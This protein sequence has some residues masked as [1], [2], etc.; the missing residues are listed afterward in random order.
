[1]IAKKHRISSVEEGSIAQEAG[2]SAGDR[3]ISING[4]PVADVFDYRT[5]MTETDL[6]LTIEKTDG[7]VADIAIGKDEYEDLGLEFDNV[8]MDREKSCRNKCI[9]CFVDQLPLNLRKTL[10]FKDDDLRLSFLTGNYVTLT[11]IDD[12]EL[13]R[14]ISYR[15]SPMN[16]S[17]HTTNPALR[18]QMLGNKHA[19]RIMDQLTRIARS[20]IM[21]NTQIVLCPGINDGTELERTLDDLESIS[22]SLQSIALVPVGLTG[23]RGDKALEFIQPFGR[24][25]ASKVVEII[26]N[27][28]QKYLQTTG[29][30]LVFGA[31]ELY[32]KAGSAIPD[33]AD[34]EEFY[35]LENG[36]GTVALF[37]DEMRTG[38]SKRRKRSER[39]TLK[40]TTEAGAEPET[41]TGIDKISKVLLVTGTD[42]QPFI[43]GFAEAL[44][45][46]YGVAFEARAVANRFFGETVTVAGLVT[47]GDIVREFAPEGHLAGYDRVMIPDLMLRHSKDKF[48]DDMTAAELADRLGTE[49]LYVPPGGSEFLRALDG[50]Y[51]SKI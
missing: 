43:A 10:Y 44:S 39:K 6:T 14:L 45:T 4:V 34:Y 17:V 23:H 8:L 5:R 28:Q 40:Q 30:R 15:L 7:S 13:D 29:S 42:A 18:V 16:I 31:D 51:P 1:M 25:A 3:L 24:S 49:V 41:G 47:G 33:A 46:L 2:I 20:G 37:L 27:R 11:N 12:A 22:G 9:F 48:L 38:I 36:V 21:L 50:I 19:G 32:L 26:T 35:Q